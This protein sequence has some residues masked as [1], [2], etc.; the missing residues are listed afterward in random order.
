[1]EYFFTDLRVVI[2]FLIYNTAVECNVPIFV[3]RGASIASDTDI[4]P[5]IPDIP[6]PYPLNKN[7]F[8]ADQTVNSQSKSTDSSSSVKTPAE[9]VTTTSDTPQQVA[10]NT[11]PKYSTINRALPEPQQAVSKR[12]SVNYEQIVDSERVAV[13]SLSSTGKLA[14]VE[15][16]YI[17]YM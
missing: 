10:T 4:P 15:T 11:L 6:R 7:L 12:D 2:I 8:P 13:R 17:I 5:P 9:T 14:I 16:D 1:M 3:E